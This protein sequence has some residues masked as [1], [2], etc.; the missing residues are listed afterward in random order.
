MY[1]QEIGCVFSA[2][3]SDMKFS[4]KL[5]CGNAIE[6]MFRRYADL[7]CCHDKAWDSWQSTMNVWL[8]VIFT[9]CCPWQWWG[10][11]TQYNEWLTNCYLCLLVFVLFQTSLVKDKCNKSRVRVL[12]SHR[13]FVE[14]WCHKEMREPIIIPLYEIWVGIGLDDWVMVEGF[15]P[16]FGI[17]Y[18]PLLLYL[19]LSS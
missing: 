1:S 16:P 14:V 15:F 6:V 18:F 17:H 8:I 12:Q 10:W 7:C 4:Y 3:K 11:L 9:W 13:D 19:H 2:L 5:L